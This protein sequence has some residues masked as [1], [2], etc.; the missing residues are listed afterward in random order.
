MVRGP[1]CTSHWFT[2]GIRMQIP[3]GLFLCAGAVLASPRL[4]K[5]SP[6]DAKSPMLSRDAPKTSQWRPRCPKVCPKTA[7]GVPKRPQRF[8]KER[9]K[10][11]NAVPKARSGTPK[12][13]QRSPIY[14]K[15]P[16][17]PHQRPLCYSRFF[18]VCL[19]IEISMEYIVGTPP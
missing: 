11:R 9:Q 18:E 10:E 1:F 5:G 4:A 6:V 12:R 15:T 7:Q 14:T 19:C 17:Q 16:D 13:V 8:P 3:A 2:S